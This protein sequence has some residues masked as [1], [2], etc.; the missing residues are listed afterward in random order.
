MDVFK[1]KIK[2]A[3][4]DYYSCNGVIYNKHHDFFDILADYLNYKEKRF[5]PFNYKVEISIELQYKI[6]YKLLDK[7][8]IELI[9]KFKRDFESGKDLTGHFSRKIFD[10]RFADKLLINWGIHHLH[11]NKI[12]AN[13]YQ[14]MKH[15]RSDMLLF[16][17]IKDGNV[18]FIDVDKHSRKHIFS[19]YNLLNII[20]NNWI[21]LID[22]FEIKG[23]IPGS[24]KPV[25]K[26]DKDIEMLRNN[27]INIGYELNG[28]YYLLDKLNTVGTSSYITIQVNQIIKA[29]KKHIPKPP[30]YIRNIE[31][32]I[33][34]DPIIAIGKF[35]WYEG[36]NKIEVRI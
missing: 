31:F 28:K 10:S 18:Y 34:N 24:M 21:H 20:S 7:K 1:E 35:S 14:Q 9:Y 32:T 12:D 11:L 15:N 29:I 5:T 3:I 26:N 16:C 30:I 4:Y 27:N 36:E 2:N 25:I 23:A 22:K 8:Y 19:M 6:N 13:N 33:I 17:S